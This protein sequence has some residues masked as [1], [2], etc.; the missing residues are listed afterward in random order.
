MAESTRQVFRGIPDQ[1]SGGRQG[2]GLCGRRCVWRFSRLGGVLDHLDRRPSRGHKIRA[3]RKAVT[4]RTWHG[5]GG[6]ETQTPRTPE[7]TSSAPSPRK[8][9]TVE[10]PCFSGNSGEPEKA[11]AHQEGVKAQLT[12]GSLRGVSRTKL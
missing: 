10:N 5:L 9:E 4:A 11:P 2:A 1:N 12:R 7:S 6:E 3:W 8:T